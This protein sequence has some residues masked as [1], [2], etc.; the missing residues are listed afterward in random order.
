MVCCVH[1]FW[2]FK[3]LKCLRLQG[4]GSPKRMLYHLSWG[5]M[6]IQNF[7][8]HSPSNTK[9]HH[10]RHGF[11]VKSFKLSLW[12]WLYFTKLC[13]GI[14]VEVSI[15]F[16]DPELHIIPVIL[17]IFWCFMN[18][19]HYRAYYLYAVLFMTEIEPNNK[20]IFNIC[21]SI[22][23]IRAWLYNLFIKSLCI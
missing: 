3:G 22:N 6:M 8:N 12:Y 19:K 4:S 20:Y 15:C 13:S 14:K 10:R 1:S 16:Y 7:Q 21:D 11:V 17:K 23:N 5:T 2:C 18:V 9:L